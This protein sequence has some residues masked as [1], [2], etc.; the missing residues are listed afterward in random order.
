[1]YP[2][3]NLDGRISSIAAHVRVGI[4]RA[5]VSVG[6]LAFMMSGTIFMSIVPTTPPDRRENTLHRGEDLDTRCEHDSDRPLDKSR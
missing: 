5:V 6:M 2:S 1:M 3:D 4:L